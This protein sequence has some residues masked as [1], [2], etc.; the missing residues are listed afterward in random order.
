MDSE[1]RL[2][3]IR[4]EDEF[5]LAEKDMQ[6]STDLKIKEILGILPEKT[7]FHS[8]ISHSYY[9]IF[10][11]AKAYLLNKGIKTEAPEEHRKTYKE[12]SKFVFVGELNKELLGIYE[13][14]IEKADSLLQI[15]KL[16]KKKRGTFTYNV[17]SEANLPYA[18]E[19]IEN[20]REFVSMIKKVLS[21]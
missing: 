8:V 13:N 6:T 10:H 14:E 19:S 20:A 9:S 2:H 21:D 7:F 12:F 1:I 18:M 15:F 3:L 11:A 17:K 4:A 16:E 5:L